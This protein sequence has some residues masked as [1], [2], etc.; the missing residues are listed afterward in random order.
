MLHDTRDFCDVVDVVNLCRCTANNSA[1]SLPGCRW[2][3]AT[4]THL[5]SAAGECSA[6]TSWRL[7]RPSAQP[8]SDRHKSEM[9][10]SS[11]RWAVCV[12]FLFV[13]RPPCASSSQLSPPPFLVE[14]DNDRCMKTELVTNFHQKYMKTEIRKKLARL[15]DSQLAFFILKCSKLAIVG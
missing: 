7:N 3:I 2:L 14:N 12:P 9:C 15:K 5:L 10:I 4:F 6:T 8:C 1:R 13:C 11:L